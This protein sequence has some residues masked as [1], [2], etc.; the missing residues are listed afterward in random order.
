[1][2]NLLQVPMETNRDLQRY[3]K[4]LAA[5]LA[6]CE[7]GAR[8]GIPY[9]HSLFPQCRA[10]PDSGTRQEYVALADGILRR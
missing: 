2:S 10:S 5:R 7:H 6:A 1:M 3:R 4:E 9:A 8:R